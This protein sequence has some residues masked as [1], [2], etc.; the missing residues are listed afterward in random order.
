MPN[1]M[2]SNPVFYDPKQTRRKRTRQVTLLAVG[3]TASLLVLFGLSILEAPILPS[4]ILPTASRGLH[5]AGIHSPRRKTPHRK[6]KPFDVMRPGA[7]RPQPIR[8]AFYVNWD[9]TSFTALRAHYKIIDLLIP[10]WLHMT[11]PDGRMRM[12]ADA[13][14]LNWLH[15][16]GIDM[17]VMPLLNNYD[18]ANNIWRSRELAAFLI[19]R[20]AQSSL[21]SHLEAYVRIRRFA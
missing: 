6:H 4:L 18:T 1:S 5:A 9:P 11:T 17:P 8:A 16:E 10:E 13:P 19:D 2:A 3:V 21:L 14:V 7:A 12:E 20:S 15:S